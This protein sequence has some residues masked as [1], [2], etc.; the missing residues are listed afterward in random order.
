MKKYAFLFL[1]VVLSSVASL[2]S[3]ESFESLKDRMESLSYN[4]F[5]ELDLDKIMRLI[6]SLHHIEP[7]HH[8]EGLIKAEKQMD[9]LIA[10]SIRFLH[11]DK[12][13]CKDAL[14]KLVDPATDPNV[15]LFIRLKGKLVMLQGAEK[16]R[17]HDFAQLILCFIKDPHW[18][19]D[20]TLDK[21]AQGASPQGSGDSNSDNKRKAPR[22][23]RFL[24]EIGYRD[25]PFLKS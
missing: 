24:F 21:D 19:D 2:Y 1:G 14:I 22:F 17:M 16:Q 18:L 3:M 12:Q 25:S 5:V 8:I 11:S 13:A 20:G 7:L 9:P 23:G 6:A 15:G 10:A 4:E